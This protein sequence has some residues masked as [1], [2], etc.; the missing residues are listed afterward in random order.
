MSQTS[1]PGQGANAPTAADATAAAQRAAELRIELARHNRAYYEDDAPLIPDA[2]YDRLFGEL[3]ALETD[4]PELQ[5]PDSPTQRVGGKPVD[6]FAPVVH[7]VPMLSLNNGFADEDVEAFDRRVSDGLRDGNAPSGDLFG[8]PVEYAAELKFD[9]LAIAL[10]YEHGV[11]VQAATRGDGTTGEDVTAN[12]R[13][14]KKIPLSLDTDNPPEVLEVRGEVLMFRADFD[15][16]NRAQEAAGEKVFVNPRNAAA[17]SLRQLD[18]KIT[19]RRPL[20]F[21]AYGVG[22][23]VGVPM[24]ETHSALL[25]WYVTLGIP[26]NE[27]REVV[28]GAAG[29]LAFYRAVGEARESLPYDID[30][31]VY[32]VNRRDEQDRL[33]FVSRAPRFALAHKFPAQEALTTLLDIEVQV[34]RTGAITPVARLAP[35]F[36]GGATVTNATLHN[37]DEIR[38]K[39]VMIGDTVIVRRAGDVIPEVVGSVL[40]R[41]PADARA[42]VMPTACP[43][44]GSAIEKLPDEVIA[45]CTGGLICAA[46]RKQALLHFAQR[47]ALDIEGLGDKLVEQLVDQQIIRTPADLFK[48]GVAKLAA[49]DRMADK[50]ASNLVAALETARHTTLA[51]FI[52]ALGIRHVGEATAKDLA[53]HFGKLDNVMAASTE[54][55]LAVPDVGPIVAQSIANFFGEPHNVEV[56]EQLRAA[57]VTW[58][59]SEP[60]AVAPLPL[61]GKTF[62]LTGTLPTLSR[63]EAKAMLE[64][65]G[66]KVAGSVSAKTD[67]VV[68]GAEA[69]SKLAKAEALG[70]PVLDEEAMRAM[71]AAL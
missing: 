61:A 17:G 66:A 2:E 20:S 42:F 27:R 24:P 5:R 53:R 9:G 33:G 60:A 51:R 65:R 29:L 4:F 19:A 23:L 68:A 32:K 38:R 36:V 34:G 28:H 16:L 47:R 48:L 55:L 12:I 11:L 21:F 35:V 46:Q 10:R 50:S 69:G 37:E 3:V 70:V 18:S 6:G 25:D 7:R 56:I 54:E 41:R 52:F 45:R 1:V 22:E 64:E 59:E 31:V 13:T 58:P 57:G 62:V 39:D 30:G 26:V 8:A 63:D 44:C 14:I 40:E 15:K 43:V 49:L 71:L 67:Y